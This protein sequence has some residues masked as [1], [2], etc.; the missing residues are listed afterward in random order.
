[1]QSAGAIDKKLIFQNLVNGVPPDRVA[2]AFRRRNIK[3]VMEDFL[4]VANKIR[5]YRFI[6]MMPYLPCETPAEA[7]HNRIHLF[8]ILAKLNLDMVPRYTK[9]EVGQ[10]EDVL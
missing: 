10:L 6:R 2:Q 3:E 4:Y 7:R 1:M 5:S 8:D 9:F